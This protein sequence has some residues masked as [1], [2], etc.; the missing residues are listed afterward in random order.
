MK[1]LNAFVLV[2]IALPLASFSVEA[3]AADCSKGKIRI[4]TSWPLQGAML[5][6]VPG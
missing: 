4:Y 1:R 5:P 3:S 6:E 2:V